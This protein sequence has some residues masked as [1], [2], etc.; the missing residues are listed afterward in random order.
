MNRDFKVNE[1]EKN[2]PIQTAV[3]I[4]YRKALT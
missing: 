2:I 4:Y 3:T 1:V